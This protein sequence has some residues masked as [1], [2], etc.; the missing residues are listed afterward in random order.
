M[1]SDRCS[2]RAETD[3]R[4]AKRERNDARNGILVRLPSTSIARRRLFQGAG[5]GTGRLRQNTRGVLSNLSRSAYSSALLTRLER[6]LS[7]RF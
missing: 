5:G 2:R 7:F 4:G 6:P 1:R 3:R